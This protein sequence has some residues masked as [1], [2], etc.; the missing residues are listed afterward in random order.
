MVYAGYVLAIRS[1]A[2]VSLSTLQDPE[3]GQ[4]DDDEYWRYCKLVDRTTVNMDPTNR[5]FMGR[6]R[7][8]VL[9]CVSWYYSV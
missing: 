9:S 5:G 2:L 1:D 4:M 3:A 8:G 7:I 6:A